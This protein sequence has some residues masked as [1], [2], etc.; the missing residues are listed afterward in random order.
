MLCCLL[1]AEH[2]LG[3]QPIIHPNQT[4][5]TN[6][7]ATQPQKQS[8]CSFLL[9]LNDFVG[10]LHRSP[11]VSFLGWLPAACAAYNPP[12][13]KTIGELSLPPSA[14]NNE[15]QSA[16]P[17]GR[18]SCNEFLLLNGVAGYKSFG[19]AATIDS[20]IDS[21]N[22]SINNSINF[23]LYSPQLLYPCTVIILFYSTQWNQSNLI[24]LNQIKKKFNFFC[25]V[26]WNGVKIDLFAASSIKN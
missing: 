7:P 10:L 5:Q 9:K 8:I 13:K 19:S 6:Q 2:W 23:M 4:T 26:R 11:L 3:A 21:T 12:R 18:A 20:I 22:H 16:R 1:C 17:L 24:S 15:I 14:V 25:F